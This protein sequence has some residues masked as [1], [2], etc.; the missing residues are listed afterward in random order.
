MNNEGMYKST[1]G[2]S[3]RNNPAS[4]P[5]PFLRLHVLLALK[6]PYTN[7]DVPKHCAKPSMHH[8][9]QH[10]R[11]YTTPVCCIGVLMHASTR[12]EE[13]HRNLAG[14]LQVLPCVMLE[15]QRS[16]LRSSQALRSPRMFSWRPP[17][18]LLDDER[19][20]VDLW[21]SAQSHILR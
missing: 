8:R 1:G 14:V 2:C 15:V 11:E 10:Q 16:L 6:K 4:A 5:L 3:T 7:Q 21:L 20:R 19:L 13:K 18:V 12:N 9:S 17:R